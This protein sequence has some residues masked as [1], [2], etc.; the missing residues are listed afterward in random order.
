[1]I[2]KDDIKTYDEEEMLWVDAT[3]EVDVSAERAWGRHRYALRLSELAL[4]MARRRRAD[5]PA[6]ASC[7]SRVS[8]ARHN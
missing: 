6:L 3:S 8:L 1:M 2:T 7:D 4:I 5:R